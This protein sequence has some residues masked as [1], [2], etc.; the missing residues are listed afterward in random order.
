[1][2]WGGCSRTSQSSSLP[3]MG[4]GDRRSRWVGEVSQD[5][6]GDAI[7][8]GQ[9]VEGSDA[10][11]AITL[12]A[13]EGIAAGVVG[14][15]LVGE[16]L[17]AVD[18]DHQIAAMRCKIGVERAELDLAVEVKRRA[19]F[20]AEDIPERRFGQR[21]ATTLIARGRLSSVKSQAPRPPPTTLRVA[22][23]PTRGRKTRLMVRWL[24]SLVPSLRL[25][26]G[27]RSA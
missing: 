14:E 16:M 12:A 26:R 24:C 27:R 21:H 1:M 17:A 10:Q 11:N 6:G 9:N 19:G 4:R 25:R 7:E 22:P 20:G 13:H 23:L 8:I 15:S 3:L 2:V 5:G 18:F